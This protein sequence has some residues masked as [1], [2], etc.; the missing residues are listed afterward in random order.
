MYFSIRDQMNTSVA[1]SSKLYNYSCLI[2]MFNA[3]NGI[4]D[5][6]ADLTNRRDFFYLLSKAMKMIDIQ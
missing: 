1:S 6:F 3:L 4:C 5:V 2:E